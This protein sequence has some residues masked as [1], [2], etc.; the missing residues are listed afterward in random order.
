VIFLNFR[1]DLT[2][3]RTELAKEGGK[4]IKKEFRHNDFSNTTIIDILNTET[5]EKL[6]KAVGKYITIEIPELTYF[7]GELSKI[8]D[9]VK[10][11]LDL[12][13]PQ[14]NGLVLVAGVGNSDITA[15]ALGPFV[16]S[17]IF[18]T[19]HLS[20]ELQKN[21]GFQEPLRPVA[22]IS[23]GVLGQTGLESSEYIKCI[24]NEIKPCC[25]ITID[26]LASRS[27]KRLGNT[28]QMSDTGIAPGSGINNKRKRIDEDFLGVPVIAIGVPTVVDAITLA[29]S[30]FGTSS[31]KETDVDMIVTPKDIDVLIKNSADLIATSINLSL[32][33]SLSYDELKFLL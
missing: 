32:Q 8:V 6:G 28:I 17:K 30:V 10:D 23:T 31:E 12:L 14:S 18:S 1:T 22:A 15:D 11:S 4:G 9:V 3:E 26:A 16:A 19:R 21:I 27:V 24:V 20:G 2:L 29:E 25:V 13:L 7:S 33:K 5:A